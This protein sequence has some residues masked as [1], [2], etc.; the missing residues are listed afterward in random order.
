MHLI[1]AFSAMTKKLGTLDTTPRIKFLKIVVIL[2][3]QIWGEVNLE[4]VGLGSSCQE[5]CSRLLRLLGS[6]LAARGA[7]DWLDEVL[8]RRLRTTAVRGRLGGV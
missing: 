6:L 2:E 7:T 3:K 4:I 8:R 5:F 1:R